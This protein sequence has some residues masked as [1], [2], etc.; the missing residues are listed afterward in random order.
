[1]TDRKTFTLTL[2]EKDDLRII[3]RLYQREHGKDHTLL[4]SI[5][6]GFDGTKDEI[7]D[8]AKRTLK[9]TTNTL[10]G[11]IGKLNIEKSENL[12]SRERV[13]ALLVK[14]MTFIDE[15]FN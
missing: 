1:M 13:L 7:D 5:F 2:D 8:H 3:I 11:S 15:E 9:S 14:F 6:D 10:M 12:E 4:D